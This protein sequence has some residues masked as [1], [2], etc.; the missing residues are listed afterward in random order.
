[1][2][3]NVFLSESQEKPP[4]KVAVCVCASIAL[5]CAGAPQLGLSLE[6]IP[7]VNY[8]GSKAHL[9]LNLMAYPPPG[10]VDLKFHGS[11]RNGTPQPAA[12]G[13]KLAF[14]CWSDEV[15]YNLSCILLVDYATESD[16]GFYSFSIS[17]NQGSVPMEFQLTVNSRSSTITYFLADMSF[18]M[19]INVII[20]VQHI[21]SV[22]NR[23]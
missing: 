22:K 4:E 3:Y 20:S 11:T 9:L 19:C 21:L 6:N 15:V 18:K 2:V 8:A 16:A 12:S 7:S 17:N 5:I 13:L 23:T 10:L 14:G 1:M